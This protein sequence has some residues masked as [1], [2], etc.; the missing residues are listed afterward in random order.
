MIKSIVPYKMTQLN[1]VGEGAP[2]T[3]T[4]ANAFKELLRQFKD[5]I[6]IGKFEDIVVQIDDPI[7]NASV[8][9]SYIVVTSDAKDLRTRALSFLAES[10][11]DNGVVT[12]M[13]L[14]TGTKH[15]VEEALKKKT[16]IEE[17]KAFIQKADKEFR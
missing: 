11:R 1:K 17:F 6:E 10:P 4:I 3:N 14:T 9:K 15:I 2:K 7:K 12:D 8:R 5:R 16:T 13:T